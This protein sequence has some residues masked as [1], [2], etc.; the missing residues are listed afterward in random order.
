MSLKFVDVQKTKIESKFV[1]EHRES[2]PS[3]RIV[4]P[5]RVPIVFAGTRPP[6]DEDNEAAH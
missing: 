2:F 4:G 1:A 6:R 3:V 5:E